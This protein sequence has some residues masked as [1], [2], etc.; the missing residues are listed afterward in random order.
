MTS[1]EAKT[2]AFICRSCKSAQGV[3]ASKVVLVLANEPFVFLYCE[4]CGHCNDIDVTSEQAEQ[5]SPYAEK[6]EP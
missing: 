2:V 5:L 1:G 4:L 6:V 3:P